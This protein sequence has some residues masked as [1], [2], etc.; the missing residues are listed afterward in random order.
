MKN[1]LKHGLSPGITV[2]VKIKT[3]PRRNLIVESVLQKA[4]YY[5]PYSQY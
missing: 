4:L 2:R 1:E 3:P 5:L